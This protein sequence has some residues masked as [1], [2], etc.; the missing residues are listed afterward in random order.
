[1]C[2]FFRQKL[3]L[4]GLSASTEEQVRMSV[5]QQD[6][7]DESAWTVLERVNKG[8]SWYM[9]EPL[10]QRGEGGTILCTLFPRNP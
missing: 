4:L 7:V 8:W 9:G 5:T 6:A 10:F 3:N 2:L 1:L